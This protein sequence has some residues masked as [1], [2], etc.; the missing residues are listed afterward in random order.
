[1]RAIVQRVS[2]ASVS[3]D[4]RVHADIKKGF[5]ILLGIGQEDTQ[6]DIDWLT[7]KVC[8]LRI[9]SDKAGLMNESIV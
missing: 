9:F 7:K 6:D 3:I 5:L 8:G 2:Q 1:M 4:G